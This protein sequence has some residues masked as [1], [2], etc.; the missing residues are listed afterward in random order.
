MA[1]MVETA[2]KTFGSSETI[3]AHLRVKVSSGLIAAAGAQEADI[4]VIGAAVL[5]SGDYAAVR[6]RNAQGTCKMVAAGTFS[7]NAV[8]YGAASGT[9]DD[10]PNGN[11]IGIALEA[12]TAAND[13]VEVLRV[14]TLEEMTGDDVPAV[15]GAGGDAEILWSTG[16]ASNHALVL[17]LGD[18]NQALH[19]TDLAAKATD[20]TVTAD[21]H[22]TLY[23]HSN[24]TPITDYFKIG[25]HDGSGA[26]IADMVGGALL[27][28]GFDGLECLQLNETAS[29]VNHIGLTNAATGNMPKIT[30]EG[31]DDTGIILCNKAGEEILILDSIASS[32]NELTIASA[33]TGL[34][35]SI[36]ASGETNVGL[37]IATKGTGDLG[38]TAGSGDIVLKCGVVAAD[39]ISLQAY[40]V[41]TTAYT[42]MIKIESH[43]TI[44]QITIG[45]D[46]ADS[47]IGFFGATP[48]AQQAKSSYNN[49]AAAT[50]VAGALAALGLVDSA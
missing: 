16:D 23:I 44:P 35:P 47:K 43:A 49:W 18:S 41:G 7:Q 11:V 48:V 29:A 10:V 27:Y 30:C 24:T 19:V 9:I 36:T 32:V 2:T 34:N 42:E 13:V 20:W 12:A 33:A 45:D 50:D 37:D 28:A 46:A 8:V 26:W 21:T 3:S 4:G 1:E 15:F 31:E 5:T 25:A 17:A 6:L 38:L 22:P 39:K 14:D 40:D